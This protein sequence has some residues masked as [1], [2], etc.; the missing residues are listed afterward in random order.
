MTQDNAAIGARASMA[1]NAMSEWMDEDV[2]LCLFGVW[3][4]KW[5]W[6]GAVFTRHDAEEDY[7]RLVANRTGHAENELPDEVWAKI[8]DSPHWQ[9]LDERLTE[10]GWDF[11]ENAVN[12]AVWGGAG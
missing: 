12:D 10:I 11:V 2:A 5:G 1:Y 3:K 6:S 4:D 7:K 8:A 9:M